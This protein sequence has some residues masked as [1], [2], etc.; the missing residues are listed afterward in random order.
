MNVNV[1]WRDKFIYFDDFV[2]LIYA[3]L[4]ASKE[5]SLEV[6]VKKTK[7]MVYVSWTER[8]KSQHNDR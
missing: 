3:S 5:S 8:R 2:I 1:Q 4:F 6:N 7:Y